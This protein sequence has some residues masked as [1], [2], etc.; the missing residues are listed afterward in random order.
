MNKDSIKTLK[1]FDDYLLLNDKSVVLDIGANIGDV[2]NLIHDKYNCNIYAY[3][4]NIA[5]C[6]YMNERFVNKN[7]I[8][9]NNCAVSNFNGKDFL[10]FHRNSKGNNDFKYIQGA[11]L[12]KDKDNIDTNKKVEVDI[13]NIKD[14]LKSFDKIN[15]IKID[16]EGSEYN[17]LPEIIKSRKKIDIVL[18]E[19]HGSPAGKKINGQYKNKNFT[20]EY[21]S[22]VNELKNLGLYNNWFYEWH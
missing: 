8:R 3:E 1:F 22:V 16:I 14:L 20:N 21:N 9:I 4:P 6:N 5:C 10:Y 2:T 12:R 19:M 18:C 13:I 7:K 17:I 15:L 11:T